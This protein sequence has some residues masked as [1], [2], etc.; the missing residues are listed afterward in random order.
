MDYAHFYPPTSKTHILM[1]QLND[2]PSDTTSSRMSPIDPPNPLQTRELG[3]ND[4]PSTTP[5]MAFRCVYCKQLLETNAD[6]LILIGDV[7]CPSRD[8][9]LPVQHVQRPL[10]FCDRDCVS[11]YLYQWLHV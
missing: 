9:G 1:K 6:Y 3:D 10:I 4:I 2:L 8:K 7:M 5:E 11:Q